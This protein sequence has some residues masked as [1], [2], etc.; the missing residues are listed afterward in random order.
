MLLDGSRTFRRNVQLKS[1]F[2]EYQSHD[3]KRAKTP[4]VVLLRSSR[5]KLERARKRDRYLPIPFF[6]F[7][8][9]AP[10]PLGT[11]LHPHTRRLLALCFTPRSPPLGIVLHA[12]LA[13]SWHCAS[14]RARRPRTAFSPP[15][16][17]RVKFRHIF[18]TFFYKISR[19]FRV[20]SRFFRIIFSFF[21]ILFGF[22]P[23]AFARFFCF[24]EKLYNNCKQTL[25]GMAIRTRLCYNVK[26]I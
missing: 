3:I 4:N 5:T 2:A 14:R 12:T 18:C 11:V 10:P 8:P 24:F 15:L 19:F 16:L 17:H 1:D 7:S 6:L 25:K 21:R 22:F 23:R 13:A 26:L 9:F 20:F